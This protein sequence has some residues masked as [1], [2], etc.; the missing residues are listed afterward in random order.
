MLL[1]G[2]GGKQ[3]CLNNR[4]YYYYCG[5]GREKR[6]RL[7]YSVGGP[8]LLNQLLLL[9]REPLA[10]HLDACDRLNVGSFVT[11]W[12]SQLQLSII[13][14]ILT[15][16]DGYAPVCGNPSALAISPSSS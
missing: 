8:I 2:E 11:G 14:G 3:A 13:G 6:K 9:K 15:G 4:P 5:R 16:Q 7:H 12:I 1:P 10:K